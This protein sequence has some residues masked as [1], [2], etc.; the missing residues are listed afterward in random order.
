MSEEN[1]QVADKLDR[2]ASLVISTV[3]DEYTE[4]CSDMAQD[5]ADG[6]CLAVTRIMRSV[7]TVLRSEE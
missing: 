6:I 7:A 3:T 4:E 5:I 2:V 1:K